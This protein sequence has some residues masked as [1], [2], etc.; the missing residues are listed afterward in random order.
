MKSRKVK[1]LAAA[2][3][4]A[5]LVPVAAFAAAPE[6][7]T[8]S[9]FGFKRK[10]VGHQ[11]FDPERHQAFED[12]LMEA[13]NKYTPESTGAWKE[14][15]AERERLISEL[16]EK[17]P[18]PRQRPRLSVEVQEKIQAIHQKVQNGE[19]TREQAGEQL[20]DLGFFKGRHFRFRPPLSGEVKEQIRAIHQK[21]Q[22]GELTREQGW[23]QIRELAPGMGFAGNPGVNLRI[24]LWKA[25]EANDESKIKELLPQLLE[26]IKERNQA[27]SDRLSQMD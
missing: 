11:R 13:V 26:Q 12:K 25:M 27:L 23:E 17:A 5:V 14:A 8:K 10:F 20:R 3:A 24:D 7:D 21:V 15:F 1:F 6:A 18:V 2:L 22:N 4:L 9:F 16:K 19:L